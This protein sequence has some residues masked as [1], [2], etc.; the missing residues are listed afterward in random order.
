MDYEIE[1]NCEQLQWLIS[2]YITYNDRKKKSYSSILMRDN[3]N[4]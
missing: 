4:T 1:F 3:S 2:S